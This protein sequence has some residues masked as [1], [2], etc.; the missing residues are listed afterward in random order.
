MALSLPFLKQKKKEAQFGLLIKE[1]G[2]VGFIFEKTYNQLRVLAREQVEFTNGWDNLIEHVDELLFSL[3]Q[4]TKT[5]VDEVIFFVFSHLIDQKTKEIQKSHLALFKNLVKN[6]DVRPLGYI[7]CSDAVMEFLKKHNETHLNAVLIE[8]DVANISIFV[9]K[10]GSKVCGRSIART[11][12]I[13]DDLESAFADISREVM[14]PSRIIIYDSDDL[15]EES[16]AIVSHHWDSKLFVQ[17]PRVEVLAQEDIYKSLFNIFEEQVMRFSPSVAQAEKAPQEEVLGFAIGRDVERKQ[18]KIVRQKKNNTLFS[19][20]LPMKSLAHLFPKMRLPRWYPIGITAII[21]LSLLLFSIEYFFHKVRINVLFPSRSIS[22]SVDFTNELKINNATTSAE[23]SEKRKTTGKRDIGE[24]AKGEVVINNFDE[25]S[26]VI[27]KGTSLETNGIKFTLDDDMSVASGSSSIVGGNKVTTP[28]KSK[29]KIT[30]FELGSEGNI[31]KGQTF[32]VA[33]YKT[34]TLFAMNESA[35]TGGSKKQ[36]QTVAKQ[37]IESLK[38]A[39]LQKGKEQAITEIESTMKEDTGLLDTLTTSSL[40]NVQSSKEVGEEANEMLL[41]AHVN[42]Q[43]YT[44]SMS[45]VRTLLKKTLDSEVPSGY[46]L[47]ENN[48]QFKIKEVKRNKNLLAVGMEVEASALK[49]VSSNE[50]LDKIAGKKQSELELVLKKE[51]QASAYEIKPK[52]PIFVFNSWIPF[53]KKNIE[54]KISSL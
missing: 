47:H 19:I 20:V 8:V 46:T 29:A 48:I 1:S 36:V 11:D 45:D 40:S 6:L 10:A 9:F 35:F 28:G 53:F 21:G 38:E 52:F 50:I 34:S 27:T 24:K 49:D 4:R 51:F 25:T 39:I 42:T 32:K 30:A 26:K 22:K 44:Y 37:D 54:L 31:T 16:T 3:E 12:S 7:E 23:L 15:H 14:L 13:V 2:G 43:Y 17:F 5:H 33:D 41:K 18:E